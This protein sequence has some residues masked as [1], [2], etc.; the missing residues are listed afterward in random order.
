MRRQ[1]I[2]LYDGPVTLGIDVSAWQ[3][4][5][6]WPRVAASEL[7]HDGRA[8]G[9]PRFAVVRAA[10]GVQT[11]R[12]SKPDP[13][14]VRNLRGAHE[15]GLL[16]AVYLYLRA[17]HGAAEQLELALEVLRV[18]GVPI[19]FIAID[20]EGRPDDPGTPDSDESRGAW[21]VPDDAEGPVSTSDVLADVLEMCASLRAEGHRAVIYSG[22]AW[23]WYVAQQRLAPRQV[24]LGALWTAHYTRSSTP[25]MPVGSTGEGAPWAEWAIWQFTGAGRVAGIDGD[26]DLNRFRGDEDALA[27]WWDPAQRSTPPPPDPIES[28]RA[29]LYRCALEAKASGA[30]DAAETLR[31]AAEGLG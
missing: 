29:E 17:Y 3:G 24:E 28:A 23:H 1:R 18:A 5:I 20:V 27:R 16:V 10:D 6:D 22:V 13:R 31:A 7:H 14:A 11:R 30:L 2:D 26:V 15:A 9:R 19:G 25:R 12:D 21:W 8:I 4:E